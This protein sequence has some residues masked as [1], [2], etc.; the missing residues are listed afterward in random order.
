MVPKSQAS[1]NPGNVRL[2]IGRELTCKTNFVAAIPRTNRA[3]PSRGT[4]QNFH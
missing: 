2:E 4:K 3:V 1:G